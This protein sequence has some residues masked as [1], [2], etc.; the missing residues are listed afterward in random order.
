MSL[1]TSLIERLFY[2]AERYPEREALVTPDLSL[3]YS[4]FA[5]LVVA[6]SDSFTALGISS[7]STIGIK[8]AADTQHLLLCLAAIRIGATSFTIPTYEPEQNQIAIASRSGATH[9]IDQQAAIDFTS[10]RE[11]RQTVEPSYQRQVPAAR[12][13]FSTS[14]TTGE[15][16]L[17]IHQ[18][19]DLVAQAHRHVQSEAE[20]FLCLASVEHNFAD[21]KSTRLNS[22]H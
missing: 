19:S 9:I 20:R 4:R 18:D 15:P 13:L 10:I 1:P 6:Q 3:S 21:R 22:S 17:V 2:F 8:C 5:E 11:R 12:L 14:G 16:K 7:Q